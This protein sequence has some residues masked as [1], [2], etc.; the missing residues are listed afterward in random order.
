[1]P[2]SKLEEELLALAAAERQRRESGEEEGP[3]PLDSL[4]TYYTARDASDDELLRVVAQTSI[5]PM[6]ADI[7]A[8]SRVADAVRRGASVAVSMGTRVPG[9]PN[10]NG[11]ILP[12]LTELFMTR[13]ARAQAQLANFVAVPAEPFPIEFEEFP[14]GAAQP[15]EAV[16]FRVGVDS[17]PPTRMIHRDTVPT[18]GRVVS[19][20]DENGRFR[21]TGAAEAAVD[22]IGIQT[23]GIQPMGPERVRSTPI[24]SR[25]TSP[26]SS[27]PSDRRYRPSAMERISGKDLFDDDD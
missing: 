12:D 7:P 20:R 1:M 11:D 8:S 4:F 16:R 2:P 17:P 25:P 27:L 23:M 19:V 24:S 5:G 15:N 10:E 22:A 9:V 18:G 13:E 14:E 6:E 3:P 21:P 26:P